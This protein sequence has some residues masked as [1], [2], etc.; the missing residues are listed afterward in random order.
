MREE[1]QSV[2]MAAQEMPRDELPLLLGE[3]EQ[4]RCTALARL[5]SAPVM[6]RESDELLGPAEAGRR[7]GVSKDYL[8]RHHRDFAFTRRVG[9]KLLFSAVELDQYI[10]HKNILTAR[11]QGGR[12]SSVVHHRTIQG[13]ST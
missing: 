12:L 1:L 13:D 9:R 3:L 8:Y 4:V 7:L 10:S 2:L 5:T 11:R 6:P